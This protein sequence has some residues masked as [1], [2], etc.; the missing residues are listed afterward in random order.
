MVQNND[1]FN[2]DLTLENLN[3]PASI[4]VSTDPKNSIRALAIINSCNVKEYINHLVAQ[5]I[6]ELTPKEYNDYN[7]I[8]N[9]LDSKYYSLR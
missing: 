4:N 3:K 7:T 6:Q 1:L 8:K 9:Y 2:L 5:N